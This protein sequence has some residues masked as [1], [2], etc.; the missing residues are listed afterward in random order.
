MQ[1]GPPHA[2]SCQPI[3]ERCINSQSGG[4]KTNA[5]EWIGVL[6]RDRN[7]KLLERRQTIGH[8]AFAAWFVNRHLSAIRHND[9]ESLLPSRDRRRQSSRTAPNHKNISRIQQPPDLTTVKVKVQNKIPG[10][11]PLA[12]PACP[13][14][15]AGSS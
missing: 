14:L 8:Q 10:P 11:W 15:D 6:R 12:R 3:R 4:Q 5:T 13:A 2:H 7:P 1:N 9:A